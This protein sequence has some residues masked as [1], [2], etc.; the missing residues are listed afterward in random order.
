MPT[1]AGKELP[2][3]LCATFL[4]IINAPTTIT[5]TTKGREIENV[6]TRY[7]EYNSTKYTTTAYLREQLIKKS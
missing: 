3:S 5:T 4:N 2:R 1:Q 6:E 7:V